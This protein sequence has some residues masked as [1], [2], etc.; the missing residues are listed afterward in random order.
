MITETG[1]EV[2]FYASFETP[3]GEKAILVTI[4]VIELF[5]GDQ[6][7]FKSK[8]EK[9]KDRFFF[10]K[11]IDQAPGKYLVVYTSI[12][13]DGIELKGEELL[14]VVEPYLKKNDLEEV[15][16]Q[17][18]EI[19]KIFKAE[20]AVV[21]RGLQDIIKDGTLIKSMLAKMLPTKKI[22]KM[23]KEKKNNG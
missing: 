6:S 16:S 11:K 15:K 17:F 20:C 18:G 4:P 12:D 5:F 22:E 9:A 21:I 3:E 8:M 7:I 13:S 23:L 1:Q 10:N 2:T 19:R 14:E